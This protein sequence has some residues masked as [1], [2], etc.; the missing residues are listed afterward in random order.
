M[1]RLLDG[2]TPLRSVLPAGQSVAAWHAAL[3][4]EIAAGLSPAHAVLLA[5]PEQT[6]ATL[7]WWAEGT[8]ATRYGDLP[9]AARRQLDAALGAI[10][11]DIRRLAE[12]GT[13]PVVRA[14][15]PA[16]RELP[17]MGHLWAVDG[18]PV[19]AG[20]GHL[21][22]ASPVGAA[23]RLHRLD[24]GVAW[25]APPAWPWQPY[26][27]AL[28]L[29][30]VLAGAAGLLLPLAA[31]WF[32]AAP[33]SCAVPPEQLEAMRRQAAEDSR[34]AEL[35]TLLASLTDEIG[36]RQLQCPV[37]VAPPP[38]AAAPRPPQP[39]A[40]PPRAD[41]PQERWDRRDL[42]MLEGCW[43]LNSSM[44]VTNEGT[45]RV[46]PIASWQQC[47]DG[48]GSGRQTLVLQDGRRC[49]GPLSAAFAP[50]DQLRVTEPQACRGT[51]NISPSL[52]T[53]RRSS[54]TEA[55]CE[56][57]NVSGPRAGI[58]YTGRFRR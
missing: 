25:R 45:G 26:A 3:V 6:G 57:H 10:L 24:D 40:P 47:F 23:N 22:A 21:D 49:E 31:T 29:L 52:R 56:G 12:S 41:L 17:D 20:W 7:S 14:A 54:D 30:A 16:L 4:A 39:P 33:A 46:S 9:E 42:S 32:T 27:A 13:A 19:L 8:N 38:P 18:R 43:T 51:V 37:P 1:I 2:S 58:L 35:R 50:D 53:C 48:Q 28:L 36:R 44:T 11:S 5:R 55:V 15:W 34:G